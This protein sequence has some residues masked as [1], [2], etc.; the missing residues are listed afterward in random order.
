[1]GTLGKR[2]TVPRR[3]KTS[4]EI[5]KKHDHRIINL[6]YYVL[7]DKV[8]PYQCLKCG[9]TG[10]WEG[11]RLTLHL[12]HIDGDGTNCR[13]GNLRWLCPNC[14]SQTETWCVKKS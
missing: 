14:H 13:K 10:D 1:M 7:R 2:W 8:I 4:A 3:R 11:R 6:R 12:D 9:N 5:F